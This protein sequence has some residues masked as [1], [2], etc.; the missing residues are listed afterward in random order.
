MMPD[1]KLSFGVDGGDSISSGSGGSIKQDLDSIVSQ[2]NSKPYE[3]KLE[4]DAKSFKDELSRITDFAKSQASE[5]KQAYKDALKGIQ[6]PGGSGGFGGGGGNNGGKSRNSVIKKETA[7]Y[8]KALIRLEQLK[9]KLNN[10]IKN[11]TAA[12]NG[13]SSNEYKDLKR[14][15]RRVETLERLL[16][17][18]KLTFAELDR[19]FNKITVS[20]NKSIG[21]IDFNDEDYNIE[22]KSLNQA[23]NDIK[24][25]YDVQKEVLKLNADLKFLV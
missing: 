9:S 4:A 7:A 2:I 1:F 5:I 12:E 25:Y 11:W 3:I 6:F 13:T 16:G 17:R 19:L 15:E 14:Q 8:Y 22:S 10:G 21:A 20:A 18:E 24:A 23:V